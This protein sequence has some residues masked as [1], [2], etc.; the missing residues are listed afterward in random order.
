MKILR[1]LCVATGLAISLLSPFATAQP[2]PARPIT[3]VS[4][5]PAGGITDLLSRIVGDELSKVLGQPVVVE[6]R[7]GAGGAIALAYVAKAA[8]DGY[9]LV[10]GGSAPSVIVPALNPN[11]AYGPKDFEAIA[12]VAGLPIV[13][14]AN[15]AIPAANL[16]EFVAYAK[17]NGGKLNCGHH[18]TGTGTH[19]SCVMFA[20]LIGTTIIDVPYKGAPQV[21]QDLLTNR[22][23]FYFGTLPTEIAY[24]KAGQLR[25]YGVASPERVPALPDGADPRRAG[26]G[27]TQPRHLERVVCAGGN[28]QSHHRPAQCRSRQDPA[29]PGSEKE[30]RGDWLHR[31]PGE[32]R[33]AAKAHRRRIRDLSQDRPRGEHQDRLNRTTSKAH[34]HDLFRRSALQEVRP[35]R[36]RHRDLF[37]QCRRPLPA[38]GARHG[39]GVHPGGRQSPAQP[40]RPRIDRA[41]TS[42]RKGGERTACCGPYPESRQIAVV[43][44]YGRAHAATGKRNAIW[45]GHHVGDGYV[46]SGNVLAGEQVVAAMA[47]A[48]EA[49]A[50]AMLAE[51]LMRAVEA[52]RDAGGQ[53]EGQNSSALLVYGTHTF[54]IVDLR[55]ELHDAPEAELRRLWDW[56]T[57]M[58]PYYIERAYSPNVPRW[59]QW[60]MDNV[61][62]WKARHLR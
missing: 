20:R 4:P 32:C 42:R 50:G 27:G 26:N 24:V 14:V 48:F 54:P 62:G 53:P 29:E 31:E 5:Y 12:F 58:V 38:G 18:G 52:G 35:V 3:L 57:P 33:R 37:S 10:M 51:R 9:T 11:A 46:C 30:D 25:A 19:L 39:R 17:A 21:N 49:C 56:Y 6:N 45:A 16:K 2:W 13:L 28:A 8:P 23:Q 7:T 55:V 34:S 61:K 41:R 59:W 22:V 60:R 47:Q 15:P 44:V 1:A 43:D 36:R 40:D